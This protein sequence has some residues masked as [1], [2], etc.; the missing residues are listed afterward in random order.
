MKPPRSASWSVV[1]APY[2][3]PVVSVTGTL[4]RSV[5][6]SLA[7]VGSTLVWRQYRNSR[8][9]Y[10]VREQLACLT[11]QRRDAV[12]VVDIDREDCLIVRRK[13]GR[14]STTS[15]ATTWLAIRFIVGCRSV[16]RLRNCGIASIH[17]GGPPDSSLTTKK[18]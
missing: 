2:A 8:E 4:S 6:K 15:V 18:S 14:R 10:R 11:G 13:P 7:G 3:L 5:D 12:D 16:P 17:S 9:K 1:I